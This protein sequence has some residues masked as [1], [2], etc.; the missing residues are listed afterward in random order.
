LR[1]AKGKEFELRAIAYSESVHLYQLV[2]EKTIQRTK[3]ALIAFALFLSI[4]VLA[5]QHFQD[6]IATERANF[7]KTIV[8]FWLPGLGSI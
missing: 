6:S 1:A 2:N 3:Y 7:Q 8:G 4:N 5:Q